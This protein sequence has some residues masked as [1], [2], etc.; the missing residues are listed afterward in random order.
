MCV[1]VCVSRACI[2]CTSPSVR[3]EWRIVSVWYRIQQLLPILPVH[4]WSQSWPLTCWSALL[5]RSVHIPVLVSKENISL[6]LKIG[7]LELPCKIF[8][9]INVIIPKT[10]RGS[11]DT[12]TDPIYMKKSS[13]NCNNETGKRK[14]PVCFCLSSLAEW[15]KAM[16]FVTSGLIHQ[17]CHYQPLLNHGYLVLHNPTCLL[18]SRLSSQFRTWHLKPSTPKLDMSAALG[19]DLSRFWRR[20]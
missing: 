20:R 6:K 16:V 12:A 4:H 18:K 10:D 1:C 13:L 2:S 14:V 19:S 17:V 7:S 8:N 3:Q 15:L 5:G 9:T 11:S